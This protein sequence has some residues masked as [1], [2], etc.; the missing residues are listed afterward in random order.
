MREQLAKRNTWI[1]LGVSIFFLIVAVVVY[2]QFLL[3]PTRAA[4]DK[5]QQAYDALV[6]TA[7]G[8][9]AA[10]E[11]QRKAEDKTEYLRTQLAFFR[12][13]YRTLNFGDIGGTSPLQ[14]A[15]RQIAWRRWLNEYFT[16]YGNAVRTELLT[17]AQ[18]TGVQLKSEIKV[19]AP[20][21]APELVVPPAN[22][23]FRPT[24]EPLKVS[25][26]GP[27]PS[28]IRFLDRVNDSSILF[29]VGRDL[30]LEGE[31]PNITATVSIT[32]YLLAAG[33]G[34]PIGTSVAA[35]GAGA[36]AGTGAEG[37]LGGEPGSPGS[38]MSGMPSPSGSPA[39]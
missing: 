21:A 4:I 29:L 14:I 15:N 20:P 39:P 6:K 38:S 19:G 25:V 28:I 36:A 16:D 23:L 22:G 33:V 30:K 32:P 26:A 2:V 13:R 31:S 9:P 18:Q 27:L 12:Q 3:K 1:A 35:A 8:L 34:A 37:G 11:A 24:G 17:A 7:Q 10:Q 5:D